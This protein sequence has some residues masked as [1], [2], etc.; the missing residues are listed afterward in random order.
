MVGHG[1]L[2]AQSP[3]FISY[4]HLSQESDRLA[5]H[6]FN[7]LRDYLQTLIALPLGTD[8]GFFDKVK[9]GT[10]VQWDEEL[11]D[12]LGTC[13]VLV[14]LL[15]VPYLEREWCG[16]EW[17]AFTLR[18]RERLPE[19]NG[20]PNLGPI[21]PVLWTPIPF[22]LPAE[23]SR[24]QFFIPANT[25]DQQK[26]GDVYKEEGVFRLIRAGNEKAFGEIVWQLAKCIQEIYYCQQ[27]VPKDFAPSDLRNIFEGDAP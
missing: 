24:V 1:R 20:S 5:E 21:I 25:A 10:A 12:A 2:S 18:D 6:F 19:A 27:L 23:V 11:A 16:K 8:I 7:E 4:A 13:Q 26:L 3:L 22:K 17:H 9:I 15:S 14:A